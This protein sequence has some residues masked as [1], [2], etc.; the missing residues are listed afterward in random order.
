MPV[1]YSAPMPFRY[2]EDSPSRSS[3]EFILGEGPPNPF[4]T[5]IVLP[6]NFAGFLR[7]EALYIQ[8]EDNDQLSIGRS[9]FIGQ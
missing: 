4:A 3:I 5:E 8:G 1:I 2:I 6:A 9:Y 7:A